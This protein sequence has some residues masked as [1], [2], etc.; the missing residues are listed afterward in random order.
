[1]M[2]DIGTNENKKAEWV[3]VVVALGIGILVAL[4]ATMFFSAK[5]QAQTAPTNGT[6]AST[7]AKV[8]VVP[9]QF[10]SIFDNYR[11]WT[12]RYPNIDYSNSISNWAYKTKQDISA[13]VMAATRNWLFMQTEER[14]AALAS[15][16][17]G[18][19]KA[20]FGTIYLASGVHL[21]FSTPFTQEIDQMYRNWFNCMGKVKWNLGESPYT[22]DDRVLTWINNGNSLGGW[23]GECKTQINLLSL[24]Y[25]VSELTAED[26]HA[27]GFLS[28]RHL[29]NQKNSKFLKA[30]L[31]R[32][33]IGDLFDPNS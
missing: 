11:G 24:Q 18:E 32:K 4:F 16:N 31:I 14:F 30:E 7:A 9:E 13:T 20:V 3:M 19:I 22:I 2:K 28:R 25:G 6:K 17:S 27:I 23:E 10:K 21:V 29:A 8:I 5:A 26:L 12:T 33:T 1:M 15:A